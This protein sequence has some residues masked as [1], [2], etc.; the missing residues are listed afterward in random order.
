MKNIFLALVLISGL[1]FAG[2]IIKPN[3]GDNI[4][5]SLIGQIIDT[6]N[7]MLEIKI[8]VEP[9]SYSAVVDVNGNLDSV[10][11]NGMF[12]TTLNPGTNGNMTYSVSVPKSKFTVNPA[13]Q[14]SQ[15]YTTSGATYGYGNYFGHI[16]TENST[17]RTFTIT[18]KDFGAGSTAVHTQVPFSI[19]V[20]KQGVDVESSYKTI[21]EL[22]VEAGL[23]F[24]AVAP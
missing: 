13:V 24:L 17:L 2:D 11:E 12:T 8:Q 7:G 16:A 21:R 3:Q 14:I 9:L 5:S 19:T 18:F 22:L 15:K 10:T 1:S 4:Q 6:I 20:H 23:T